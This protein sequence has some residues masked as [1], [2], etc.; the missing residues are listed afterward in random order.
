MATH[1]NHYLQQSEY[2]ICIGREKKGGE[3][4][5]AN[6]EDVEDGDGDI[7]IKYDIPVSEQ[8]KVLSELDSMN[9]TAYSLFGSEPSLMDTLA[10]RELILET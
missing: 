8:K 10:V 1:R 9:I 3:K 2:T 4:Y 5:F 7:L 6:H